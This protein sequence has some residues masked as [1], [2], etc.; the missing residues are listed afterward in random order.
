VIKPSTTFRIVMPV[1]RMRYLAAAELVRIGDA[2]AADLLVRVARVARDA[3]ARRLAVTELAEVGDPRAA[4]LLAAL[5]VDFTVAGIDRM[6]AA[7]MLLRWDVTRGMDVL[8]GLSV[9][10]ALRAR[11]RITAAKSLVEL[12]DPRGADALA[13]VAGNPAMTP[14]DAV[15]P[16]ENRFPFDPADGPGYVWHCHIIDHEDNEMMRPYAPTR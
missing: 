7:Q 3:F 14:V 5:A 10:S 1:T 13:A 12:R 8:A 11:G 15:A 16:G 9:D 2:R 4:G 6:K